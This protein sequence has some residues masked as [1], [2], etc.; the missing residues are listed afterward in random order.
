MADQIGDRVGDR[1][2]QLLRSGP[3]PEASG[4]RRGVGLHHQ[5]TVVAGQQL[6]E[7][8]QSLAQIAGQCTALVV[9]DEAA[10]P[11][12]QAARLGRDRIERR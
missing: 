7:R 4:V 6:V 11:V 1:L 9:R 2:Q 8:R 10:Q 3:A 5:M 12:A